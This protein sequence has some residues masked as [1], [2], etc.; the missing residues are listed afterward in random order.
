[1]NHPVSGPLAYQ[2]WS[3][4]APVLFGGGSPDGSH[5]S[6][7]NARE[8]DRSVPDLRPSLLRV[9]SAES[10]S[11]RHL[12]VPRA[13]SQRLQ[14]V[15]RCPRPRRVLATP[16]Q[17]Q[18]LFRRRPGLLTATPLPSRSNDRRDGTGSEWGLASPEPL[19]V[20]TSDTSPPHRG[21]RAWPRQGGALEQRGPP[22]GRA[23]GTLPA[24]SRSAAAPCEDVDSGCLV[25]PDVS[26][27]DEL[28]DNVAVA[29]LYRMDLKKRQARTAGF[30]T[31]SFLL[32]S[33]ERLQWR[34]CWFMQSG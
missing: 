5:C 20:I 2:R 34:D 33:L 17:P 32:S 30:E 1:V 19:V 14:V 13:A 22:S 23:L 12:R 31:G 25:D 6:R 3:F 7:P 27:I 9:G 24:G 4:V 21:F 15:D 11:D 16:G 28:T 10:L 26:L 18:R 29:A 8:S